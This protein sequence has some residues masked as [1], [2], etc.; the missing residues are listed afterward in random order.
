MELKKQGHARVFAATTIGI[1]AFLIEVEADLSFGIMNFCIVGL[2]D[3]SIKE[4]KDR[5][6][7]AFKN[8]GLCLPDRLITINL[9]PADIKKQEALFDVPMAIAILQASRRIDLS[10]TFLQETIFL[11]E[12]ALDGTIK[13]I[14]GA[15]PIVHSAQISGKKRVILPTENASEASAIKSM[16]VIGVKSLYELVRFLQG[17]ITISPTQAPSEVGININS[18]LNYNQVRGQE[19][20]KKALM[21]A[22]TGDHNILFVGPPGAGKTMLAERLSTILPAPSFEEMIE[23]SKI[24]SVAGLLPDRKLMQNRPFRSP[25][26]TVSTIGLSGGGSIPIP[27]EISLAHRGILFLDELTEFSRNSIEIMRQP[28]E[29]GKITI[30]RAGC[31]ITYPANFL[32]IAAFNPCPCGYYQTNTGKCDC[33]EL[34][35]K[36]YVE[37]LSG[38]ILDRIDININVSALNYQALTDDDKQKTLSS[39]EMHALV[40]KGIEMRIKRGQDVPNSKIL[41]D[42]IPQICKL[43]SKAEAVLKMS[44]EKFNFSARSYHKILKLS[45]TIADLAGEDEINENSIKQAIFYRS[46][47]RQKSKQ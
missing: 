30:A 39:E 43:S 22:A 17:E 16:D 4:S 14:K 29:S 23:I 44:F 24:Y 47:D 33:S 25:H 6:R 15:L 42:Q 9:A 37:K 11:G 40:Q 21:V 26:H 38:P 46:L 36:K 3:K 8:S 5:I 18:K 20:A 45:R 32:L 34:Q 31:S 41:S 2:P 12:L 10:S 13:P 19:S 28:M 7:A 27:G 1:E 35:V